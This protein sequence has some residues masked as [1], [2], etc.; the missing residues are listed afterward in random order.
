LIVSLFIYGCT[1]GCAAPAVTL[2]LDE[3][4][5]AR[6]GSA[7]RQRLAN[8][9]ERDIAKARDEIERAKLENVR[10]QE[11]AR[12]V[13]TELNT[14]HDAD[15]LRVLTVK[16][17]WAAARLQWRVAQLESAHRHEQA[18]LAKDELDKAEIV[19]RNGVDLDI[20]RFRGQSARFHEMWSQY[21]TKLNGAHAAADVQERLLAEAKSRYAHDKLA[22]AQTPDGAPFGPPVAQQQH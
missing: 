7:D 5:S 13:D 4:Q 3:K 19:S 10:A 12:A 2:R 21:N 6:I 8:T 11:M 17:Q 15:I 1:A 18:A 16:R 9:D 20:A 14:T 22:T